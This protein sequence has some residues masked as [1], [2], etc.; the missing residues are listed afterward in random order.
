MLSAECRP[1]PSGAD[2]TSGYSS[3]FV[4]A[5][6]GGGGG[7]ADQMERDVVELALTTGAKH[8]HFD[9]QMLPTWIHLCF[10]RV[11]VLVAC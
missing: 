5:N 2:T 11:V 1:D 9:V 4:G 7:G 6:G 10:L 8:T 3:G